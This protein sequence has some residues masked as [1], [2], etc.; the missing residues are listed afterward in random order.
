[1]DANEY[2]LWQLKVDL[3]ETQLARIE[4]GVK[5]V[6]AEMGCPDDPVRIYAIL[7]GEQKAPWTKRTAETSR[8]RAKYAMY[9]RLYIGKLR[10]ALEGGPSDALMAA[11]D[12]LAVGWLASQLGLEL[13]SKERATKGGR[14]T[15]QKIALAAS[16]A[17]QELDRLHR[18]WINSDELQD[19]YRSSAA[20]IKTKKPRLQRRTIE[21]RLQKLSTQTR[22]K[23]RQ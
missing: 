16:K 4:A 23:P 5:A 13:L 3:V 2:A 19:V 12:A 8:R 20:Y 15:G 17:D 18:Q 7:A 22:P 14:Q 6:L 9:A 11:D 21:R 10:S 1:M